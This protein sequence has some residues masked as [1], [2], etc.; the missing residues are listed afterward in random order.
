MLTVQLVNVQ[1]ME[2]IMVQNRTSVRLML[3][4]YILHMV[5]VDFCLHWLFS[6]DYSLDSIF[7]TEHFKM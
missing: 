5:Y 3:F 7:S 2:F 1:A 6:S 4:V